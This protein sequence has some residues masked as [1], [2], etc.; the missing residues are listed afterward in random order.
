M[1]L[2]LNNYKLIEKLEV[3]TQSTIFF[4]NY[5]RVSCRPGLPSSPSTSVCTYPLSEGTFLHNYKNQTTNTDTFL[6]SNPQIPFRFCQLSF[7][8]KRFHSKSHLHLVVME[9]FLHPGSFSVSPWCPWLWHIWIS[10]TGFVECPSMQYCLLFPHEDSGYK[11]V[12]G[13]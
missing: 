6:P 5:F 2:C 1:F 11:T 8:V 3:L 13:E 4:L 10:H 9:Q 7:R 12:A